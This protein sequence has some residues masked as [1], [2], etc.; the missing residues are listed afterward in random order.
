[1]DAVDDGTG[2]LVDVSDRINWDN[3]I[4]DIDGD[5]DYAASGTDF[6]ISRSDIASAI[7]SSSQLITVTLNEG[8]ATNLLNTLN[9][10]AAGAPDTIDIINTTGDGL[11]VDAAGNETSSGNQTLTTGLYS[12]ETGPTLSGTGSGF[13]GTAGNYREYHETDNPTAISLTATFNELMKP[14]TSFT[15]VMNTGEE[16]VFSLSGTTPSKTLTASYQ[17]SSSAT[18]TS[19]L[20]VSSFKTGAA[21]VEDV[22]GNETTLSSIASGKNIEDNV[23]I[24]IDTDAPASTVTGATLDVEAG[25]ITLSG[26]NFTENELGIGQGD[27]ALTAID[28]SKLVWDIN[29]DDT[30]TALSSVNTATN[31]VF[32]SADFD[33]ATLKDSDEIVL[34]LATGTLQALKDI[35]GFGAEGGA[36]QLLVGAGVLK[37]LAGNVSD[38]AASDV[39]IS[40]DNAQI[41]VVGFTTSASGDYGYDAENPI[42]FDITLTLSQA[43]Q[44]GTSLVAKFKTENTVTFS[45]SSTEQLTTLTGT[46]TV[47]TGESK[48][49]LQV[50]EI[51]PGNVTD[52]YG[53]PLAGS[54]DTYSLYNNLTATKVEQIITI[55]TQ[56]PTASVSGVEYNGSTGVI[57]LNGSG[58][59]STNVPLLSDLTSAEYSVLDWSQ[60]TWNIVGSDRTA[61]FTLSASKIASAILSSDEKITITLTGPAKAELYALADFGADGGQDNIDIAAEFF[62]DAGGNKQADAFTDVSISYS[63][64][65]A[66]TLSSFDTTS[67]S[68]D[69]LYGLNDT[70]YLEATL[71]EDV[72]A[73]SEFTAV[74]GT[75]DTVTFSTSSVSDTMQATYQILN[76]VTSSDLKIASISS[77]STYDIYAGK[78]LSTTLPA[79]ENLSDNAAIV[80]DTTAPTATISSA[81]YNGTTGVITLKGANFGTLGVENNAAITT[82]QLTWDNFFWDLEGDDDVTSAAEIFDVNDISA[83]TLVNSSTINI[84][85]ASGK[86]TELVS[87]ANF[88]EQGSSDN[89]LINAGFLADTAGNAAAGDSLD[90]AVTFPDAA[91]PQV[92]QIA[93]VSGSA[94]SYAVSSDTSAAKGDDLFIRIKTTEDVQSGATFTLKLNTGDTLTFASSETTD[95]LVQIYTVGAGDDVARLSVTDISVSGA[96]SIYGKAMGSASIPTNQSIGQLNDVEIDT[97]PVFNNGLAAVSKAGASFAE[98][99]TLTFNFTEA[100]AS[101]TKDALEAVFETPSNDTY[102]GDTSAS[103]S[104]DGKQLNIVL[105]LDQD[106]TIGNTIDFSNVFDVAGNENETLTFTFD[107]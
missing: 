94:G 58:F 38:A 91:V 16:V 61:D 40:Y 31:K 89:I 47:G 102:A 77:V 5:S 30:A 34:S 52:I 41:T 25:E 75:G 33:S 14:G 60:F 84:S 22:Y 46:Y 32:S 80:I 90:V 8:V 73:G 71:S 17:V 50:T 95:E 12:D 97:I 64:G 76:T 87:D 23:T 96:E 100:V 99:D 54:T 48:N 66:P 3:I 49:K 19:E 29:S 74:L 67:A 37:D 42:T 7:I 27:S 68:P 18:D 85:L 78:T 9:F 106:L 56:A 63:D 92:S 35:D 2:A 1:M 107:V 13:T 65:I 86:V 57:T 20:S 104:S 69:G 28:F 45:A 6:T 98:G 39:E 93:V 62:S 11:F 15:A 82:S 70:V 24:V 36:D 44:P 53:N 55:D 79:G 43:V 72:Q 83:V 81:S 59:S 26:T 10:G 21:T 4:W 105:E 103:W 88:A 51:D 101:T